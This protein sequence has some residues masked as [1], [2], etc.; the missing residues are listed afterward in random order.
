MKHDIMKTSAQKD[1]N[2][3]FGCRVQLNKQ[4]CRVST[5]IGWVYIK[6]RQT[7]R[8][9]GWFLPGWVLFRLKRTF[10]VNI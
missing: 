1:A 8:P 7:V 9:V 3:F 5:G 10:N 2:Y 4:P 6:C